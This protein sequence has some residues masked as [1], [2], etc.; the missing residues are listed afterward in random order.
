MTWKDTAGHSPTHKSQ[1]LMHQYG[2]VATFVRAAMDVI[3]LIN[4]QV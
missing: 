1:G 2:V 4:T 3:P